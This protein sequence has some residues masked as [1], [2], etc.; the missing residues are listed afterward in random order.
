MALSGVYVKWMLVYRSS[1]ALLAPWH[2]VLPPHSQDALRGHQQHINIEIQHLIT[3]THPGRRSGDWRWNSHSVYTHLA[4]YLATLAIYKPT[5]ILSTPWTWCLCMSVCL[6]V[7]DGCRRRLHLLVYLA[8]SG[9]SAWPGTRLSHTRPL[10]S[11][12]RRQQ[13]T[14]CKVRLIYCILDTYS[15]D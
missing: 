7:T 12:W 11:S 14:A 3:I 2:R 10:P 13:S 8:R 4:R 15:W 6:S 1:D 9:P 5:C